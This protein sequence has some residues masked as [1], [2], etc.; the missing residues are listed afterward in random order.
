MTKQELNRDVK[1]L[2]KQFNE[3]KKLSN[4]LYFEAI[5]KTI[6]PEFLRLYGADKDITYMNFESFKILYRMN[7]TLRFIPLHQFAIQLEL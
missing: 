3:A 4:N 5:E 7:L 2:L 1:R 6:K